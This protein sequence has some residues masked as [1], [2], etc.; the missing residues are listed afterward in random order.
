[1]LADKHTLHTVEADSGVGTTTN[2]TTTLLG[3]S[4]SDSHVFIV[5]CT[6]LVNNHFFSG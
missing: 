2:T 4:L 1:M 6:H 3:V 5:I